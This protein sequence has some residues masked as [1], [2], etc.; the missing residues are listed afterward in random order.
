MDSVWDER[1][2]SSVARRSQAL[3]GNKHTLPVALA[4][5]EAGDPVV[6]APQISVVLGGHVPHNRVLEGLRRLCAFGVLSELPYPG[7]PSARLFERRGSVYWGF[8]EEF[9]TEL[10]PLG[11]G[12]GSELAS[13]S[14]SDRRSS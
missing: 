4:V 3:H 12:S 1:R 10:E 14:A 2:F 6:T 7:R 13:T 9:A 8:I 5:V 11:S